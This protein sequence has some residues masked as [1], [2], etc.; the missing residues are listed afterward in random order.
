[1]QVGGG[2]RNDLV[3]TRVQPIA[4]PEVLESE[5]AGTMCEEQEGGQGTKDRGEDV[6]PGRAIWAAPREE[7][8]FL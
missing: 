7:V 5:D 1:M 4:A 6:M 8:S 3:E 2:V